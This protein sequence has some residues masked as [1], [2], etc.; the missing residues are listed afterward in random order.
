[1]LYLASRSPRRRRLLRQLGRPFRIVRSTYRETIHRGEPPARNAVRNAVGKA[2]GARLPRGASGVVIGADTLL[3]FQGRI[4]GKPRN[5][6]D[7]RR[8]LR[9]LS[10]RSHWVYTGL[11]LYHAPAGRQRTGYVKTKVTFKPLT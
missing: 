9:A 2:R 1:M 7:A 6:S 10:G 8:M 5:L 4:L 3:Y 11:C